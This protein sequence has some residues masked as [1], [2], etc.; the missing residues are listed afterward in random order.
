MDTTSSVVRQF[1]PA[2]RRYELVSGRA[3]VGSI[4]CFDSP[5]S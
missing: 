2:V 3:D 5:V 1:G 4:P